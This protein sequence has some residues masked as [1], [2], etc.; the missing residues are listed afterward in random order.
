MKKRRL[1]YKI[2]NFQRSIHSCFPPTDAKKRL[3][4]EVQQLKLFLQEHPDISALFNARKQ[5]ILS[6]LDP[7]GT[8]KLSLIEKFGN[9]LFSCLTRTWDSGDSNISLEEANRISIEQYRIP[10]TQ[11]IT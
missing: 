6:K 10:L 4:K 1:R 9:F 3:Y 2:M 5:Y 11:I 7:D 8:T